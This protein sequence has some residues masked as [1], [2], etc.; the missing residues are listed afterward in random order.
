MRFLKFLLA[1][2]LLPTVFFTLVETSRLFI[3]VMS[4]W[5]LMLLFLGGGGAYA[6]IHF[7]CYNFSRWYVLGHEV[8]HAVAALLCG[9][10]V[11][12]ISVREESGY[13]KMDRANAWIV[14]APYIVPG[15]VILTFLCYLV[16]DLCVDVSPYRPFFIFT[17]GFF[18]AFHW[19]QTV[20]TLLEADQ[21]DLKL[22]GGKVFSY[23]II[24]LVNLLVL[25]VVLKGLF[26][27]TVSL[28][29]AAERIVAGSLN[30]WRIIV[31]YIV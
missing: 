31:N 7:G 22:A 16:L 19:I 23:I 18:T 21:P 4:Q 27:Q 6:L 17:V 12:D 2:C 9:S 15:Y 28:A 8:T 11:Q 5:R 29:L 3:Q 20:K 25:A 24:G 1:V 30:V 13:V 10:R 14:L 26:P